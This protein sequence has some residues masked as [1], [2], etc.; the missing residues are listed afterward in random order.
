MDVVVIETP[1]LG[2]RSYLIHDGA[3]ALVIDPQRD[4]DRVEALNLLGLA[5]EQGSHGVVGGRRRPPKASGVLEGFHELGRVYE[6]FFGHAAADHAG[7]AGAT[8]GLRADE[9]ERQLDDGH[10][11]AVLGR[12][13]ARGAHA[14]GARPDR[15]EVVVV[16]RVGF[17]GIS[18]V[19]EI[20]NR[21]PVLF[22]QGRPLRVSYACFIVRVIVAWNALNVRFSDDLVVVFPNC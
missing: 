18:W 13:D 21:E 11:G 5:L 20:R 2:D 7:P 10:L 8:D 22:P 1:Q 4:I 16:C 12:G 9:A 6:E 3:V 17:H 14:S 15:D 19:A